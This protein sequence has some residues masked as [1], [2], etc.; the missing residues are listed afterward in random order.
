[1]T[2]VAFTDPNRIPVLV[3]DSL[4]SGPDDESALTTPDHPHGISTVFPRQSGYVP[5]YLA[6]KTALINSNLA[7]VMS[8]GIVHMRAFREDVQEHFRIR[9]DCTPADVELFLQQYKSDSHGKIVLNHIDALLLSTHRINETQHI[10]H[11]LT[12]G[13]DIPGLVEM[14]SKNL[15]KVLA[16]GCGAEGLRTA[17]HTIDAYEFGGSGAT[18]DWSLSYEAISR[19]LALIAQLH[20]M[21][22]LTSQMLLTYWG[23]GY[24]V[25]YRKVGNGL[26]YLKDYTILFWTLDLEDNNA[27]YQPE[28]FVKYER[29][30]DFS[31]LTSYRQGIF[32][33]QGMMDVGMP[34]EPISIDRP[35][36]EYLNSDV[37]MNVVCT[38]SGNRMTGM[39][40]FCHRYKR[41]DSNPSMIFLRKD[42]RAEVLIPVKWGYEM[43]QFIR[44]SERRKSQNLKTA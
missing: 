22:E 30:D 8:G 16:I 4:I 1:M 37:H 13:I 35:D 41:G 38:L 25:I 26:T 43:S 7:I 5:T 17:I 40:H 28:G 32:N 15:G 21:D 14:D 2:M 29:R 12:S 6:R 24:E 18:E 42:N 11:L 10:Y 27:G 36:R 23:G 9:L 20:K 33:L 44:D 34:R 3:A 19:N 39:Y 31:L